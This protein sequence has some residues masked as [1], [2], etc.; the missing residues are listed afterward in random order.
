MADIL[1]HNV[2]LCLSERGLRLNAPVRRLPRTWRR[3]S[4]IQQVLALRPHA[5]EVN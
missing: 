5:A 4:I 1:P 3:V 2:Q